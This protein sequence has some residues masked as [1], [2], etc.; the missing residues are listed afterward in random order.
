MYLFLIKQF[1]RTRTFQLG[2]LLILAL[3]LI[4]IVTGKQF[5]DSQEKMVEQ[6]VKNQE[7]HI[8]RNL[9]F[10]GDDIGLLLYYLKFA[11][12]KEQNSLA[13]LSIGQNDLNPSIQS[14]KILTLE[15]QKYDTDLVNPTKLLFGNLDLSFILVYIFPLLIIAFTYNLISEEEESG[16]WKMV[17]VTVKSKMKF[18]LSKL[19]VRLGAIFIVMSLLYGVASWV[20]DIPWNSGFLAFFL[21]GLLYQLFWFALSAWV[22]SFRRHSNVNA[23]VLLSSWLILVVLLPAIIN[24]AVT[25]RYPVPEALT[26]MIKQRDGYHQKWDTNKRETMEQFYESYPQFE[27]YGYPPE[28]GF[29]WLWYYAMQHLGDAE[30]RE[31]SEAMRNKMIQRQTMSR[32]IAQFFPSMHTLLA[33]NELAE[34]SLSHHMNFLQALNDF[35]EDTRLYFYPKVFSESASDE[36]DWAQFQPEFYASEDSSVKLLSHVAPLLLGV[37]IFLML[38][39]L[40]YRKNFNS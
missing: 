4:S 20:L 27:K 31:E 8:A 13:A 34:T 37:V 25:S 5:L 12:I 16:T 26:T 30:S 29:S 28:E 21:L 17:S 40:G 35:H 36:V 38:A 9:E 24:N 2:L 10:H 39:G 7:E 18:I 32:Q 22:I 14:V 3:G 1:L 6:A 19:L 15:G 33:F 11:L 23:L